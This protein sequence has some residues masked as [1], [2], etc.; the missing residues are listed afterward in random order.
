MLATCPSAAA[1]L[2]TQHKVGMMHHQE[3]VCP[4][5]EEFY[6]MGIHLKHKKPHSFLYPMDI[7]YILCMKNLNITEN[8]NMELHDF[9]LQ[10]KILVCTKIKL[11]YI[12]LMDNVTLKLPAH[13]KDTGTLAML[14]NKYV[15]N[16]T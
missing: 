3:E 4:K 6:V 13:P 15:H 16:S 9:Q 8:T 2:P 12:K 7:F 11:N 14:P 5:D 10:N 1:R